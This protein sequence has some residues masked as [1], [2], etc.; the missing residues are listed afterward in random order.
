M[1]KRKGGDKR[2][3]WTLDAETDPFKYQRVPKPFIWGLYTGAGFHHFSKTEDMIDCIKDQDVIVYAHNGGKFD[4]H[5]ILDHI[6]LNEEIK[7]IDGRMVSARIG[8]CEV[9]DSYS[10]FP[11][12]LR[13]FG[14]KK[15]IDIGKLE[16]KV[17]HKHM[18][19]IIEYLRQDCVGLWNA[20]DKH[21]QTYGRH[22][23]Q[24]GASMAQW[25][26]ISGEAPPRTDKRFFEK[27]SA[28]YFGGRVGC[29]EKGYIRGPIGV[30]DIRSAYPWAMLSEHP[31]DPVYVEMAYPH[32]VE[33]TDMVTLDCISIGCLPFRDNRGS[34]TFPRDNE[35]RRYQ[36]TGH[37]V[38]AGIETGALREVRFVNAVR[39]GG[40][41]NFKPYINHFYEGRKLDRAAAR[42]FREAGDIRAAEGMDVEVF[43]KKRY[44]TGLY[45][46]F[47]ANPANY[48]N[49]Q[50]VKWD[51]KF[52]YQEEGWQFDGKLGNFALLRRDLDPWQEHYINIV[53]AASITGQVRAHLW[54]ALDGADGPIYCDTDCIMARAAP[55][56]PIGEE[57]GEWNHEG[58]AT[59]GWFA[60]KK[61]YYLKGAF[62]NGKLEKMAS[63]GVRPDAK[64]IKAAALG[65]TVTVRSEAPT[66]T[67][68]GKRSVY[69]QERRIRMTIPDDVPTDT[70]A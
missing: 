40:L 55:N 42:Q 68:K 7:N 23:T 5:L 18:P 26:K 32:T 39:F 59:D 2:A 63:K 29:F 41:R 3:F 35:R 47:A 33:P 46:K 12:P 14:F 38:L 70:R 37:E 65:K 31:Y 11:A 30:W 1:A 34:I 50:C 21:E 57:L 45:G 22:L 28:Y 10:L 6:N 48:G 27:F 17:R 51:E 62:E 58:T 13:D 64:K 9:R 24:A 8:T 67:L 16:A 61:L 69:F 4:F 49:F 44:M 25:Q 66:F 60:G 52:D 43:F 56:L 54:R 15:E 20:L 19:E 36:V 53:T